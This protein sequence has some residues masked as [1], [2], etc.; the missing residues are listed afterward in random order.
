MQRQVPDNSPSRTVPDSTIQNSY[1][2]LVELESIHHRSVRK[3]LRA[4]RYAKP[5]EDLVLCRLRIVEEL[6]EQSPPAQRSSERDAQEAESLRHLLMD[7]VSTNL[8]LHRRE[9]DQGDE[10]LPLG[11]LDRLKL[12]FKSRNPDREAW[13]LLYHR[14][15]ARDRTTMRG[16]AQGLGLVYMTLNRRLDRG[17]RL[18]AR[19]LQERE[20]AARRRLVQGSADSSSLEDSQDSASSAANGSALDPAGEWASLSASVLARLRSNAA[21]PALRLDLDSH[22]IQTIQSQPVRSIASFWMARLAFLCHGQ[23]EV[24]TRF[25]RLTLMTDRGEQSHLGRWERQPQYF[26]DLQSAIAGRPEAIMVLLGAP[27]SGKT[28][29]LRRLEYELAARSL[30]TEKSSASELDFDLC[31]SLP[32]NQYQAEY[33]DSS[34]GPESSDRAESSDRPGPRRWLREQWSL[35]YPELAPLEH[36]LVQHRVLLLLDGLN[37]IPHRDFSDYA[38]KVRDWK[39]FCHQ[40]V[41][42]GPAHRVVFSCRS[43][44]YSTPLSTPELRVPQVYIEPLDDDQFQQFLSAYKPSAKDAIWERLVHTPFHDLLRTAFFARLLIDSVTETGEVPQGRAALFTQFVHRLLRRELMRDNPRV[45]R[46]ELLDDDDLNLLRSARNPSV[47]YDLPEGGQMLR[48]LSHLAFTMQSQD[49]DGDVA[50]ISLDYD[51]ALSILGERMEDMSLCASVLSSSASVGLLDEDRDRDTLSFYHQLLQEYFASRQLAQSF[52]AELVR[53]EW[54]AVRMEPMLDDLILD[55]NPVDALPALPQSGWEESMLLALPM[56]ERPESGLRALMRSNLA[57]AG[58]AASQPELSSE[59]S[60]ST[61][62]E[63]RWALVERSRNVEADLRDRVACGFALGDLGDP[64]FETCIGPM[65]AFRLPPLLKIPGGDYPIGSDEAIAWELTES[66]G[67]RDTHIPRHS[68][69][70]EAFSISAFAVTNAEWALFMAAGGYEDE[71]Y[72]TT[73]DS[74]RWQAGEIANEGMRRNNRY[75]RSLFLADMKVFETMVEEKRFSGEGAAERWREWLRLDDVAFESALEAFWKPE[76]SAEPRYWHDARFNRPAQPVVGVSWYEALAYCN[77]LSRQSGRHFDLPS[78]VEW[79]AVARGQ[80]SRAYPWGNTWRDL[81]ANMSETHVQ[82]TSPIAVFPHGDTPDKVADLAGNTFEWT[83]SLYRLPERDGPP[84]EQN[85]QGRQTEPKGPEAQND[86]S[87]PYDPK[88]GRE[89]IHAP[90]GVCRITRGCSWDFGRDSIDPVIRSSRF[91]D[92]RD[93]GCGFRVVERFSDS[94]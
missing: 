69:K 66:R 45:F 92:Y 68:V 2:P 27:G 78:E 43:L 47:P 12:D 51:E 79:E 31:V 83:R 50:R 22:E 93:Y 9:S 71:A 65:G 86:F 62:D 57:L 29:L 77:W 42:Y 53:R 33:V 35:R 82:S 20:L 88:D 94:V 64:R 40:L 48:A 81:A 75:F 1:S 10:V 91:A 16:L 14:Y 67:T 58:R 11:E 24:S 73:R 17:H 60:A 89:D 63:L 4:L 54:R 37:E 3:A 21:D 52:D 90:I 39:E 74:R 49:S 23:E 80:E 26:E 25:V 59:V 84:Q 18:L 70:I 8:A 85:G 61:L 36:Y 28:T 56:M 46:D 87:Y 30:I 7:L 6:R 19:A 38:H 55:L 13:G 72:W 76:R 44:D 15:F 32:L 5:L 34:E 41:R